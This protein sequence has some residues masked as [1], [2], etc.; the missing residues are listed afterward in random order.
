MQI[1]T[2]LNIFLIPFKLMYKYTAP[3]PPLVVCARCNANESWANKV[4]LVASNHDNYIMAPALPSSL[5]LVAAII[6]AA[7]VAS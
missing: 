7:V 4:K 6:S 2:I 5:H 1:N 3:S